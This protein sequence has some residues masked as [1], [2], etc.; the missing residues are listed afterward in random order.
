VLSGLLA[1]VPI[2]GSVAGALTIRALAIKKG[3]IK[4]LDIEELEVGRL[5]VR[6]L[7]ID[8]EQRPGA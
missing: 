7:V 1:F 8:Q 4:R 5:R 2:I 6:E 3:R